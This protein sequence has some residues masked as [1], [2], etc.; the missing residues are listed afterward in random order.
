MAYNRVPLTQVTMGVVCQMLLVLAP[1]L[2]TA[3]FL[4]QQGM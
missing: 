4:A 1:P 2:V 3:V